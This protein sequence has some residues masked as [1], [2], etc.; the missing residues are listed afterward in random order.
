MEIFLC[1]E[2]QNTERPPF[3][4]YA[5]GI[6]YLDRT[7]HQQ[8]EAAFAKLAEECELQVSVRRVYAQNRPFSK[9]Y[10]YL[11]DFYLTSG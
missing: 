2:Q 9:T 8:S 7:H 1:R 4:R 3:G 6:V 10:A 11:H 5:T